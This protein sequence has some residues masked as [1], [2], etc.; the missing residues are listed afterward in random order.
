MRVEAGPSVVGGTASVVLD[1]E[2]GD[3]AALHGDPGADLRRGQVRAGPSHGRVE[4]AA[5]GVAV[6]SLGEQDLDRRVAA[7]QDDEERVVAQRM[8]LGVAGEQLARE[9][10][11]ERLGAR[12][13]PLLVGERRG[14]GVEPGEVGGSALGDGA[15]RLDH[16]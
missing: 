9:R 14:V 15:A 2:Q 1:A 5:V 11:H 13:V 10:H 3:T 8:A 12:I 7:V 16:L 6:R 4:Q